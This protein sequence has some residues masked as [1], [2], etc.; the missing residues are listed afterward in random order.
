MYQYNIAQNIAI[1]FCIDLFPLPLQ[2]MQ[3]MAYVY[4]HN[5]QSYKNSSSG[6]D[7]HSLHVSCLG[8][9]AH[10]D[11]SAVFVVLM[12]VC[13][14]L[15]TFHWHIAVDIFL[16]GKIRSWWG[17]RHVVLSHPIMVFGLVCDLTF[18]KSTLLSRGASLWKINRK[19]SSSGRIILANWKTGQSREQRLDNDSLE[20]NRCH[21]VYS[22]HTYKLQNSSVKSDLVL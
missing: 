11:T 19:F 4:V 16:I 21:Q 13:T 5:K 8:P 6:D 20:S 2:T 15:I 10:Q 17:S 18:M 22:R 3:Y 7:T 14:G 1:L 12:L 9:L